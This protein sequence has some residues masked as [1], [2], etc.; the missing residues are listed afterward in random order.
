MINDWGKKEMASVH[1]YIVGSITIVINI[2]IILEANIMN[3]QINK[4]LRLSPYQQ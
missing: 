4:Y 3:T 1:L 2:R